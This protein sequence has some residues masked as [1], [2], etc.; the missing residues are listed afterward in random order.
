MESLFQHEEILPHVANKLIFEFKNWTNLQNPVIVDKNYIVLDGNHRVFVFKQLK[1][2]YISVCK[3]D[4]FN[5]LTQLRYWFRLFGRIESLESL[6]QIINDM[7]GSFREVSDREALRKALENNNLSCGIQQGNFYASIS[8][9]E[10]VVNDAVSAYNALE[11]IQG[12]LLQNGLKIEYIPC[13]SVHE[14]KFCDELKNSE[15]IIWTPQI[16]KEM[17]VDAV[18]KKKRFAPKTTRHLIPARP[19][20]VNVPTYW[21]KEDISLEEINKRF[22]KLLERK[23]LRRFGPGQVVDGRYYEEELFIFFD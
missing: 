16:T 23:N 1:F 20:N 9:H 17:V 10:D 15:V 21:F 14:G 8:F 19:L 18:K 4:Y 22:L 5:E 2:K 7:N 3:V 13:K 12:K 11:K 6:K